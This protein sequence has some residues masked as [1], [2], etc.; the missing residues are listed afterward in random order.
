MSRE[1]SSAVRTPEKKRQASQIPTRQLRWVPCTGPQHPFL[2]FDVPFCVV[3]ARKADTTLRG[4]PCSWSVWHRVLPNRCAWAGFGSQWDCL[5][6]TVSADQRGWQEAAVVLASVCQHLVMMALGDGSC[7]GSV[8][9][10]GSWSV[11]GVAV[12]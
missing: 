10:S 12:C 6:A 11:D 3:G 8:S 1:Q 5:P 9:H 7:G 2:P 4:L